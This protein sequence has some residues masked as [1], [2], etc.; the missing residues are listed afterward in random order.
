MHSSSLNSV[1][2]NYLWLLLLC[3]HIF[4][5]T[6]WTLCLPFI[7]SLSQF[8]KHLQ[9]PYFMQSTVLG[10][11][12]YKKWAAYIPSSQ[13][14]YLSVGNI[15]SN[16]VSM[17]MCLLYRGILRSKWTNECRSQHIISSQCVL[18]D[19]ILLLVLLTNHFFDPL[20]S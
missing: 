5:Y 7:F 12:W 13:G 1:L 4:N 14:G 18:P 2:H 6:I 8:N 15:F 16:N 10:S 3:W 20:Q 9:S 19:T 11:K 17:I